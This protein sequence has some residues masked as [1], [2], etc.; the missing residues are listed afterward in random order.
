MGKVHASILLAA[1][2]VRHGMI[3]VWECTRLLWVIILYTP[4]QQRWDVARA[5]ITEMTAV[6]ISHLRENGATTN[7]ATTN[8]GTDRSATTNAHSTP[9]PRWITIPHTPT[10]DAPYVLTDHRVQRLQRAAARLVFEREWGIPVRNREID[11]LKSFSSVAWLRE[12]LRRACGFS[13][14]VIIPLPEFKLRTEV[15]Y[16]IF[17]QS[18]RMHRGYLLSQ[19]SGASAPAALHRH[20]SRYSVG[21]HGEITGSLFPEAIPQAQRQLKREERRIIVTRRYRADRM[22][23]GIH[24]FDRYLHGVHTICA[25]PAE[26]PRRMERRLIAFQRI[27]VPR[28]RGRGKQRRGGAYGNLES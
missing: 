12:N 4:L 5:F 14:A 2:H 27:I 13:P 11:V 1:L 10:A 24:S 6:G 3:H 17:M 22:R 28:Q 9:V 25:I 20:S 15:V 16:P 21:P 7:G 19:T 18:M 8:A 23:R 26:S